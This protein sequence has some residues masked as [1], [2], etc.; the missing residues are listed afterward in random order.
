MIDHVRQFCPFL[1]GVRSSSDRGDSIHLHVTY[2][3]VALSANHSFVIDYGSVRRWQTLEAG[4]Q[5]GSRSSSARPEQ[6][7]EDAE[8]DGYEGQGAEEEVDGG[9][10]EDDGAVRDG[11][12]YA[13]RAIFLA[14]APYGGVDA[15]VKFGTTILT[16]VWFYQ[17]QALSVWWNFS[18]GKIWGT[19]HLSPQ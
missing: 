10:L 17:V 11:F 15:G 6:K 12:V 5:D 7:D 8:S 9:K 1:G 14:V 2:R 18:S 19:Q 13:G 4:L 3:I 16:F